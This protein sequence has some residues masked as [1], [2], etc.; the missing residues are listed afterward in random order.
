MV[1][2]VDNCENVN[3]TQSNMDDDNAL[4]DSDQMIWFMMPES[5][6]G[7]KVINKD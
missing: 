7:S 1:L 4:R 3:W 6:I 2:D 5:G